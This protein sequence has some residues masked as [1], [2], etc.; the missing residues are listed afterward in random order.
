MLIGYFV[1]NNKWI[2]FE[3]IIK[4][5]SQEILVKV[6][7]VFVEKPVELDIVI[8]SQREYAKTI[9]EDP[10]HFEEGYYIMNATSDV[11]NTV[12]GESFIIDPYEY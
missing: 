8:N 11:F 2:D 10:S 12:M 1:G 7:T 3:Q 9:K 4:R 5:P 6:D